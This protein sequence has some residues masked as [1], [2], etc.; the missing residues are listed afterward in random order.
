MHFTSIKLTKVTY[1]P[2]EIFKFRC[3][4]LCLNALIIITTWRCG[5]A[6]QLAKFTVM[7]SQGRV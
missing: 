3:A 5:F 7:V 1:V 6:N 2:G 4:L